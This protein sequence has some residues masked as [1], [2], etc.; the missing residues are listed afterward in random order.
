MTAGID[1]AKVLVIGAGVSGLTTSI[2]LQEAGFKDIVIIGNAF[3]PHT[4]SDVAAGFWSPYKVEPEDKIVGWGKEC[5]AEWER[6]YKEDPL[7]GIRTF[8]G[9]IIVFT[10]EQHQKYMREFS[11]FNMYAKDMTAE[12]LA[13]IRQHNPT[14]GEKFVPPVVRGIFNKTYIIDSSDHMVYLENRFRSY[15]KVRQA[16]IHR[17]WVQCVR[18]AA[19]RQEAD[20]V[21]NCAGVEGPSICRDSAEMVPMYGVVVKVKPIPGVDTFVV[22]DDT[23]E[24]TYIFPRPKDIVLGGCAISGR[25]DTTPDEEIAE[26][27]IHRCAQHSEPLRRAVEARDEGRPGGLE[28]IQIAAG[29]RPTRKGGIRLEL[30]SEVQHSEACKNQSSK[31]SLTGVVHNYGHGGAGWTVSWGCAREAANLAESLVNTTASQL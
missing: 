19:E 3:S 18:C 30:D 29:L 14:T 10:E 9:R 4:T 17:A 13:D 2:A 16:E 24:S 27:I 31:Y 6:M 23:P 21:I 28:I 11:E 8:D 12:E 15:P 26:S 7:A 22:V 1:Q 5:L 25:W 20:L